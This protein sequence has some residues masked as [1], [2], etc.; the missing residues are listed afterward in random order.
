[1]TRDLKAIDEVAMAV[2]EAGNKRLPAEVNHLRGVSL[3][4]QYVVLLPDSDDLP[5]L[6]R[7]SLSRR[8]LVVNRDDVATVIDGFGI[9]GMRDLRRCQ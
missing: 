3:K 8:I 6:H 1:L 2:Q 7:K 4:F 9:L 5:I